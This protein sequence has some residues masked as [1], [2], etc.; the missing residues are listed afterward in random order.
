MNSNLLDENLTLEQ[1]LELIDKE[2]KKLQE[3]EIEAAKESGRVV[4]PID[5]SIALACDGC[6]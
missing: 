4:A 5:P 3:A 1:K 2:M 6:Q